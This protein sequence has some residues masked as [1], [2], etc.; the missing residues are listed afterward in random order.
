MG[1]RISPHSH[2]PVTNIPELPPPPLPG[3]CSSSDTRKLERV[4]EKALR[5][6]YCNR[7]STYDDLLQM[8][9][10]P[11]LYNRRL[12]DVVTLMY[13][14][15]NQQCPK[16]ISDLFNMNTSG[17]ALSNVDFSIP[18]FN[19]VNFGRH[20]IRYLGPVLWAILSPEVRQSETL[21][22]FKNRIR[23]IHL[24]ALLNGQCHCA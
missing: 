10:L 8:A 19:T 3:F 14:V 18:R 24:S 2:I 17:H 7:T 6:V 23:R 22:S 16:C 1:L 20:S 21:H 13:K 15:K 12:Q 5:A 4:Q 11:M 9:K